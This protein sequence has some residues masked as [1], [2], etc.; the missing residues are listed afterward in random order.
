MQGFA[1][2]ASTAAEKRTLM[3][4]VDMRMNNFHPYVFAIIWNN[5][6]T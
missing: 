6:F 3:E 2:T 5:I 4:I 1:P